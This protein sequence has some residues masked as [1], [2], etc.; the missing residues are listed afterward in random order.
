MMISTVLQL[1]FP[2]A[3]YK[4]GKAYRQGKLWE[5]KAVINGAGA[6]GTAIAK[7]LIWIWV[8]RI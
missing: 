7:M 1:W 6:A 8:L 3:A 5:I 2:R 4:C